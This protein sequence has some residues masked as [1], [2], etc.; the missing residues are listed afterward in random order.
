MAVMEER[1]FFFCRTFRMASAILLLLLRLLNDF[2]K[3]VFSFL[4][5]LNAIFQ[6]LA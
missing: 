4:V 1:Y 3:G 5:L 2:G 6:I